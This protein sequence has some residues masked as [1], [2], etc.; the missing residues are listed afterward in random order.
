[1]VIPPCLPPASLHQAREAR[2]LREFTSLEH[3]L[4]AEAERSLG[5]E[6]AQAHADAAAAAAQLAEARQ[7]LVDADA[8]LMQRD[9]EVGLGG[10]RE[11]VVGMCVRAEA[12]V[13]TSG[14]PLAKQATRQAQLRSTKAAGIPAAP[15]AT[16]FPSP[17]MQV[18]QLRSELEAAQAAAGA[19]AAQAAE[20]CQRAEQ[21]DRDRG[22]A[23]ANIR[24]VG[25]EGWA[26]AASAAHARGAQR[27][28]VRRPN[29]AVPPAPPPSLASRP[30]SKAEKELE[31]VAGEAERMFR[32]VR[33]ALAHWA[34][35]RTGRRAGG[36]AGPGS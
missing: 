8:A 12:T 21:Y 6:A 19:A 5:A 30:C 17:A 2:E 31:A 7:R 20:W 9:D 35:P 22:T 23:A 18:R 32:Q 28:M 27:K 24:W 13:G 11:G 16:P 15:P 29:G 33:A 34:S 36:G 1:M 3:G 26:G 4:L 10:R 14:R 25:A